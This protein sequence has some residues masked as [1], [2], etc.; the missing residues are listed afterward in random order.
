MRSILLLSGGVDSAAIAAIG[1]PELGLTIDY[2]Q[3]P[4]EAE[5]RAAKV[6]ADHLGFDHAVLRIDLTAVGAGLLVGAA[7]TSGA[8]TPEWFPFRNQLLVSLASA[9][10]VTRGFDEIILGTVR[11]DGARHVDGT[12]EFAQALD[13]VTQ[14]QEGQIRVSAPYADADPRELILGCGL[15][16]GVLRW[17]HSCHT[18][19]LACGTCPGCERRRTLLASL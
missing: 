5:I 16:V 3:R 11:G 12:P 18:G 6:I 7:G 2:G 15:P 1:R 14:M 13:R 19:V 17:T 9:Y 8:P 4:A 10:A